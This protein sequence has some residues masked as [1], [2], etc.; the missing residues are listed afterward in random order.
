MAQTL[1]PRWA[2]GSFLS[3]LAPAQ[4]D[5]LLRRGVRRQFEAGRPLLREGDLST[6]VELIIRGFVKI[7][8][9][10]DGVEILMG[11]RMPGDLLGELAGLTGNPRIASARACGRVVSTVI[12][13][14]EFHRYLLGAPDVSLHMAASMGERLRW[15]NDRRSDFAAFPAEIRLARLL[16]DIAESCGRH[17]DEGLSIMVALS[18]PELA[19]MVGVS[20]ATVQKVL[21]ELREGGTIRT[22]YRHITVRDM[23]AL[24][25]LGAGTDRRQAMTG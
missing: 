2:P 21:R 6:H 15:A 24:R 19:T 20:E 8:N 10:L 22:G 9:V 23:A 18:Q 13:R 17:T 3:R 5:E 11:I 7:T 25:E 4:V 1:P 14:A 12:S 16:Y